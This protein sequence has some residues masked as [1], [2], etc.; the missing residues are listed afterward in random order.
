VHYSNI[1]RYER[2]DAKPS[3]EVLNRIAQA[4]YTSQDYWRDPLEG[5]YTKESLIRFASQ[6]P[7]FFPVAYESET[8]NAPG[9]KKAWALNGPGFLS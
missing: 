5:G 7:F 2:G 1:G 3:A 8:F 9:K 4:L 6:Q